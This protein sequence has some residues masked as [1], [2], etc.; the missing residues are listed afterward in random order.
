MKWR[1]DD[2]EGCGVHAFMGALE[3]L[4]TLLRELFQYDCADLDA[5]FKQLME[6][7]T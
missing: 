7:E 5:L 1:T 2:F 6:D 4:Q 3:Q